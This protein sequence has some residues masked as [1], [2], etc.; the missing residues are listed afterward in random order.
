M[1][2][3]VQAPLGAADL[4]ELQDTIYVKVD[5]PGLSKNDIKVRVVDGSLQ[6][7]GG[8]HHDDTIKDAHFFHSERHY[9][10]FTRYAY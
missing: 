10:H 1:T 9:G 4:F 6:V 5:V 3:H 7:S 2:T 8:R